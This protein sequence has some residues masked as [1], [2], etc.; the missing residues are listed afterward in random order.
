MAGGYGSAK[1]G[2]RLGAFWDGIEYNSAGTQG[3]VTDPRINIDRDVNI[4]D[5]SNRLEWSGGAVT[6]GSDSNINVSGSGSKR[7]KSCS[8]QWNDLAYGETT[9]VTFKAE[10]SGINYAGGTI[11]VSKSVTFK[12]RPYNLP[13]A[14][15]LGV[16]GL[17]AGLN[18]ITIKWTNNSTGGSTTSAPYSALVVER[19]RNGENVWVAVSVDLP[20]TTTSWTDTTVQDNS[21]Y[22]YRVRAKN[23][24]GTGLPS[25]ASAW[26]YTKPSA[27]NPLTPSKSGVNVTALWENTATYRFG[28]R[29][30][31]IRG[32]VTG[33]TATAAA[34]A[35][36]WADSDTS[37][38]T[39]KYLFEHYVTSPLAAGGTVTLYSTAAESD[40]I[41][42]AGPPNAP[43][44]SVTYPAV[45][46]GFTTQQV[47][48]THRP[49]DGVAQLKYQ[50]Q[51]QYS[52]DGGTTW[53]AWSASSEITS[54]A[55]TFNLTGLTNGRIYRV[56]VKTWANN[57]QAGSAWSESAQFITNG[58]PTATITSPASGT[59]NTPAIT[60][61]LGYTDPEGGAP[62]EWI[63]KLYAADG[64]TVLWPDP[65]AEVQ[66]QP[67]NINAAPFTIP[68]P[69]E[70]GQTYKVTVQAK[71][72]AGLWSA[73]SA[74]N[75]YAIEFLDPV[76]AVVSE[77]E[78]LTDIGAVQ[79][80][81]WVPASASGRVA[82]VRALVQRLTNGSWE[83]ICERDLTS[84]GG[85]DH[86]N[87]ATNPS[88]ET[89]TGGTVDVY[90][91]Q[92]TAPQANNTWFWSK[93]TAS[94][95]ADSRFQSGFARKV[96][97]TAVEPSTVSNFA[98]V[99]AVGETWTIS[100]RA[101]ISAGVTSPYVSVSLAHTTVATGIIDHGDGTKTYW[102]TFTA[103]AAGTTYPYFTASGTVGAEV[104]AGD[105]LV[106]RTPHR[107]D[108]FMPAITAN[109]AGVAQIAPAVN[110]DPDLTPAW[111]GTANASMSA[112]RGPL[113]LTMN[114]GGFGQNM[115]AIQSTQWSKSGSKSL[116]IIPITPSSDT[117]IGVG[118]D[119]GGIRLGMEPGKT[120]T[121][122]VTLRMAAP[123]T[124]PA[125]TGRRLAFYYKIGSGSYVDIQSA[126]AP[127][128][129]GEHELRLTFTVPVGATEAFIRLRN[130]AS[131]GNGETWWDNFVLV[132]GEYDGPYFEGSMY[133]CIDR[134]PPLGQ[135][136]YYRIVTESDIPTRSG[137]D[138]DGFPVDCRLSMD[139][140]C[141]SDGWIQFLN[142]GDDWSVQARLVGDPAVSTTIEADKTLFAP[143]GRTRPLE[144]GGELVTIQY[145][146]NGVVSRM[147][148]WKFA[149]KLKDSRAEWEAMALMPAPICYRDPFGRRVFVSIGPVNTQWDTKPVST[150][151]TTLTEVLS[152]GSP[153]D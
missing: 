132:E 78:C 106:T 53:S 89:G 13:A 111:S 138:S 86:V 144:L 84:P 36:S 125:S 66:S 114:A 37:G 100:Y 20:A 149:D 145:Q 140:C 80:D 83:D 148:D 113:A 14:P 44:V 98:L 118:G 133:R 65:A 109:S 74:M 34:A 151:S 122:M 63:V 152:Y 23:S 139:E 60:L 7:I 62:A 67:G 135:E 131:G 107:L 6:D 42:T 143:V 19:V 97:Y 2:V 59:L 150:V 90:R 127:N 15:T 93:G 46:V 41:Q 40:T 22:M 85:V 28:T 120:Y 56:Q 49:I 94:T 39:R 87:L 141:C 117:Y 115:A 27:P 126:Q 21:R 16:V 104:L 136:V 58:R 91:N 9:T 70:D 47:K 54:T 103:T 73:V 116:R 123:Q 3:R 52:T 110:S 18:Q 76:D 45:D 8:P 48:F 77:V 146:I 112:L 153:D 71:D 30:T 29:I 10:M 69:V 61:T 38:T 24:R 147:G 12:A 68:F 81:Y 64:T 130:G 101:A 99:V 92:C 96:V 119:T 142:A 57:G 108:F 35:T 51:T 82:A 79:L 17:T 1:N 124:G 25:D 129:A 105:C 43:T 95:V 88:F 32:G 55:N 33:S 5:S 102:K 72:A 128:A 31:P 75:T 50:Y 137:T 26:I 121:A 11:S 134:I 4:S